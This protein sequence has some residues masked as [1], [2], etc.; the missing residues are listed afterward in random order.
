[1]WTDKL[2]KADISFSSSG[3]N[4]V[5]TGQSGK[6]IA[7]DFIAARAENGATTLQMK[8]GSTSYGGS[9]ALDRH[10]SMVFENMI[11][12]HDGIITLSSGQNFVLNSSASVQVSG[13]VRYR[14]LDNS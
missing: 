4:T 6:R 3:D 5:I 8:D 11:R 12:N 14:F 1:M 7:I 10:E 9:H 13:F 2:Y